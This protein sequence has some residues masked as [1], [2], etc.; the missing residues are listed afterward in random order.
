MQYVETHRKTE[1]NLDTGE[2]SHIT[3]TWFDPMIPCCVVTG[4]YSVTT[5]GDVEFTDVWTHKF[6]YHHLEILV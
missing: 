1:L 4:S 6:Q 5:T 2:D 3:T